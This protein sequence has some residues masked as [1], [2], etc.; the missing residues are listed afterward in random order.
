MSRYRKYSVFK[1]KSEIRNREPVQNSK[2]FPSTCKVD[3]VM[4]EY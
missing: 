2:A 3:C 1:I 4:F